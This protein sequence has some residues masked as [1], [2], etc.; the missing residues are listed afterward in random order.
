MPPSTTHRIDIARLMRPR[1]IAI[2]GV[3]PQR[4]SGGGGVLENLE[5][6]G[7]R[8]EI[9][10]VSRSSMEIKGR[11]CVA[12]IDD[13][14]QG[15]DAVLLMIP[16]GAIE[17]A[18]SACARR[19]VGAAIIFAAG[20]AEAG[21][22][23]KA[24]QERIATVAREA[25]MAICGPNCLGIMNYVDGI[26]LTFSP[27]QRSKPPTG[28]SLSIVAQSGGLSS[29]LR[30]A[31]LA[32]DVPVA[33]AV[34]T[35]NEAVLGLE[36]YIEFL[37][38]DAMTRVVAVFAEQIR[39]PQR[40]LKLAACARQAGKAIVLLH[41][42]RS[43]AARAAA[44]SHTGALAGDHAVMRALTAREGVIAVDGLD[45]LIDVS[46]LMARFP[47]MPA[48]GPAI[49]TDS[50]AFKGMTLDLAE[51][52]GLDL[53]PL[54]PATADALKGELPDF[55]APGNPLDL[56]AQGI[57]D[58]D[59]YA[60]TLKPL[61]ADAAFGSVFV[62]P[63]VSANSAF[64][65]A[66]ITAIL[67][68][69]AGAGK[70]AVLGLL[71]D[72]VALPPGAAENVRAA[73]IPLFRSPERGLRALARVIAHARAAAQRRTPPS[74]I[75]APALPG[76]GVLPEHVAK[77]YLAGL[78][79]P[80][81]KAA[82]ARDLPAAQAAAA[83]IGYPVALK[84]QAGALPHKSDAGGVV[85]D[86]RDAAA[87]ASAWRQMHQ[88]VLRRHPGIAIDGVL[89]EAMAKGGLEMIVG[90][91][92]DPDWGP[93][94]VIGLGGIW[95]EALQDI[96]V[97]PADLDPSELGV[98]LEKLKAA[99]LIAGTR[100]AP[101]RDAAALIDIV[102]RIGALVRARA[103]IAEIEI[104]PLMVFERGAGVLALDALVV[105]EEPR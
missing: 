4:G 11:A 59:L 76:I 63:I 16:R 14:P 55:M 62:A 15:V 23:W 51:A 27:Q 78:G 83:Q 17:P 61:F 58:L 41:P 44:Q 33:F 93:V 104:N 29:I 6:Y 79:I 54:S 60:R 72:E 53:P 67:K 37:L 50:G 90:A 103:E 56:T 64:A 97:L 20:F 98:E 36:D 28:P 26:P 38:D 68:A 22:E 105:V 85:L 40:F 47:N 1:S 10:L 96:L 7:Y 102:G 9:H 46:E 80:V 86:I 31:L 101:A 19:S 13:L 39:Q 35:G 2:V 3:S 42:G 34:S 48:A 57:L 100:G 99:P 12:S 75:P 77:S 95:T 87:L 69:A 18:I 66:K 94:V 49:L 71:G 45:E 5:R 73:G 89:V 82:L 21:G 74:A 30:T 70:P 88:S 8:G 81:P 65:A 24:A 32:R 52:V 43:A 84:L 25:G 92:R 91:R